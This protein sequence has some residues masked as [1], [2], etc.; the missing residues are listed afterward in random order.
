MRGPAHELNAKSLSVNGKRKPSADMSSQ[1][2]EEAPMAYDD[3]MLAAFLDVASLTE[4]ERPKREWE[5]PPEQTFV[6]DPPL[7]AALPF[8]NRIKA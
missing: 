7:W 8:S 3:E 5:V 2:S 1:S 4:E 6:A